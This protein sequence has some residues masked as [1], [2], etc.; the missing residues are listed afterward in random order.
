MLEQGR[1]IPE[2]VYTQVSFIDDFE[3]LKEY[4][5]STEEIYEQY[6]TPENKFLMSNLAKLELTGRFHYT[7]RLE[8]IRGF[9]LNLFRNSIFVSCFSMFEKLLRDICIVVEKE[10]MTKEKSLNVADF[11]SKKGMEYLKKNINI[12]LFDE[13]ETTQLIERFIKI[14]N[15]IVH[16]DSKV[17]DNKMI[18]YSE[19]IKGRIET[20][21]LSESDKDIIEL[22]KFLN[23]YEHIQ[24]I[25]TKIIL[26]SK[27]VI[28]AIENVGLFLDQ[29]CGRVKY[30]LHDSAYDEVYQILK[31]LERT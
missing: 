10:K 3:M 12:Q 23:S 13:I 1:I 27:C 5:I 19:V 15:Y 14:R 11:T 18:L 2:I 25:R 8:Y 22:I 30:Y 24:L 16:R 17:D 9:S 7:D 20:K 21:K 31:S 4:F 26:D 28:D 29:L 6:F